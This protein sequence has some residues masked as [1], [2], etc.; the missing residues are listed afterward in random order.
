MYNHGMPNHEMNKKSLNKS[1]CDPSLFYYH[2]EKISM[3]G[4][5]ILITENNLKEFLTK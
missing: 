3:V 2:F 4:R 5:P 1:G